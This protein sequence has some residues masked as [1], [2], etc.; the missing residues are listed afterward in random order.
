[1]IWE[2]WRAIYNKSNK[3]KTLK[4]DDLPAE[5]LR[6]HHDVVLRVLQLYQDVVRFEEL[7]QIGA[8]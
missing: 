5:I 6:G 2:H 8:I 4:D 7:G 1:M 3:S